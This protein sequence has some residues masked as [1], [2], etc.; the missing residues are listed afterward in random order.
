MAGTITN[1]QRN[2]SFNLNPDKMGK[3]WYSDTCLERALPW[4]TKC[5]ERPN[6]PGRRSHISMLLNLSLWPVLK[7]NIFMANRM[8]FQD[9]FY[10]SILYHT[11]LD[12]PVMIPTSSTEQYIYSGLCHLQIKVLLFRLKTFLGSGLS[13]APVTLTAGW[14]QFHMDHRG[15]PF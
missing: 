11:N 6:I 15:R 12:M 13:Y 10:C 1:R 3:T 14:T 4:E 9:R 5:L 8:V 2:T 7:K